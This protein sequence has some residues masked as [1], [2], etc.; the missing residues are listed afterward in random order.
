MTFSQLSIRLLASL[1]AGLGV[2]LLM[3]FGLT[4]AD[5]YQSGHGMPSLSRPW[6][7][8]DPLGIH[9]SRADVVFLVATGFV[10][11]LAWR[12]MARR[13]P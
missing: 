5:L 9:L 8:I 1:G 13:G 2:G 4:I 10:A 6:L 12:G 11:V 7:D 3:A